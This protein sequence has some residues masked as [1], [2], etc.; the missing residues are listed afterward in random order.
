MNLMNTKAYSLDYSQ[1]IHISGGYIELNDYLMNYLEWHM[2][3]RCIDLY[4]EQ[5]IQL[6]HGYQIG[7]DYSLQTQ[8]RYNCTQLYQTV[9]SNKTCLFQISKIYEEQIYF[10]QIQFDLSGYQGNYTLWYKS[11]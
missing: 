11:E 3:A 8:F 10:S 9:N 7:Y 1:L 4:G 5:R 2:Y 6:F